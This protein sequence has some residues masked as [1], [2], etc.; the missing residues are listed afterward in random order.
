MV[1]KLKKRRTTSDVGGLQQ[2]NPGN[3]YFEKMKLVK[4]C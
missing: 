2:Q 4:F 1:V 3:F